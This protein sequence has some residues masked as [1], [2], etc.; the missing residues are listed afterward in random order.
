MTEALWTEV[1]LFLHGITPER[2]PGSHDEDYDALLGLVNKALRTRGKPPFHHEPIR[3]E[4]G[5]DSGQ[6][7]LADRLL[8]GAEARASGAVHAAEQGIHDLTLN[9]ARVVYRSLRRSFIHGFADLFFYVSADGERAVRE[10]VFSCVAG[11][12]NRLGR[13]E[14]VSLTVFA[15]SAGSVIAHDLLYHIFGSGPA[16]PECGGARR[17]ILAARDLMGRGRLRI[18]RLYT[19]G[20]PIT[21]LLVRADSLLKRLVEGRP[22]DPS[23]LGFGWDLTLGNPR[24]V[25][26]WDEDDIFAFPVAFN[27]AAGPHGKAVEDRYAD[28][29]DIFPAVHGRYWRSQKVADFVAQTW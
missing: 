28:L 10:H 17:E 29:G 25:N 22:L 9:P 15:H 5:W 11:A 7:G 20:S 18:R 6:A 3:V 26:F 8:A 2:R 16:E 27:Y 13:G 23:E 12:A 4:W 19:L 1:P 24:W 14:R 21:P